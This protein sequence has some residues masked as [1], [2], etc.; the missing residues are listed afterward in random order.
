MAVG[1][2]PQFTTGLYEHPQGTTQSLLSA[3]HTLPLD[4]RYRARSTFLLP[5]VFRKHI[6]CFVCLCALF[7]NPEPS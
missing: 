5:S 6:R 2:H 4:H 1:L 3:G 7:V